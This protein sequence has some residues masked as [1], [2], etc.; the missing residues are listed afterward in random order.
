[1]FKKLKEKFYKEELEKLQFITDTF[2]KYFT[3]RENK[4]KEEEEEQRKRLKEERR[5]FEEN[6][7][8]HFEKD[9]K[10][11]LNKQK[12]NFK[13]I[14]DYDLLPWNKVWIHSLMAN[15]PIEINI[16]ELI[17]NK[18]WIKIVSDNIFWEW[19]YF[20]TKEECIKSYN[21]K[22]ENMKI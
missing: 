12:K 21:K 15:W 9:I 4:L 7:K 16:E 5:F 10:D 18:K 17:I 3:D 11:E 8:K 13:D 22:L 19:Q 14:I 20:K 2:N 1:M 6:I